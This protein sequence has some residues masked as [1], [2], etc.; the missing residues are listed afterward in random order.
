VTTRSDPRSVTSEASTSREG[1]VEQRHRM[2]ARWLV[3]VWL[4]GTFAG[5]LAALVLIRGLTVHVVIGLAFVALAGTHVAQRRHTVTRLLRNLGSARKWFTRRGRL[6]WSD[7]VLSLVT[8]NVVA[9]GTYDL[10]SG[11]KMMVRLRDLG[12]PLPDI[13]WHSLSA[14]V[15]L[16]CLCAHVARRW[17]RL[18]GSVIR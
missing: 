5:S 17:G 15:L 13:G 16:A 6:A 14:I 10:L 8:L 7:L 12:I 4:I 11:K 3:H 18:R 2:R 1:A 9:S